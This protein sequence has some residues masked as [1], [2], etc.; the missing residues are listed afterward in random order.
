MRPRQRHE[1]TETYDP[2]LR[3]QDKLITRAALERSLSRCDP[4]LLEGVVIRTIPNGPEKMTQ[5]YA[6]I[7]PAFFSIE[8]IRYL[9]ELG[10]QHLLADI[11]S[12]DR[13]DDE[14]KLTN[15]HIFWDVP[16]GCQL[17]DGGILLRKRSRS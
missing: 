12:I 8:G 3:P 10:V 14:G 16:R 6:K 15:H 5:D 17:H 4:A 9:A 1:T 11:P 7:R 13:L 2:A